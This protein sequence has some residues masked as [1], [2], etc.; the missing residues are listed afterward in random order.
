MRHRFTEELG[1]SDPSRDRVDV[2]L[3]LSDCSSLF[4]FTADGEGSWG[5]TDVIWGKL[6]LLLASHLLEQFQLQERHILGI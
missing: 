6:R 1:V 3:T 5:P 2:S 4:R